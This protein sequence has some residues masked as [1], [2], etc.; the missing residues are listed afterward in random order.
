MPAKTATKTPDS[1]YNETSGNHG[2]DSTDSVYTTA[3][4]SGT[5]HVS[6]GDLDVSFT[7]QSSYDPAAQFYR[8]L[9][10]GLA[11]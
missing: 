1:K 10:I 3:E 11:C 7:S 8:S 5:S 6:Q 9:N 2:T 4:A